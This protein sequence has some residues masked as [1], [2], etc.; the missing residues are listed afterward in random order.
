L[1][2]LSQIQEERDKRARWADENIRRRHNYVPFLFNMLRLI[3][4]KGQINKLI[5][6]ARNLKGVENE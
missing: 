2:F 5:E 4:E 6:R 3:A 1:C